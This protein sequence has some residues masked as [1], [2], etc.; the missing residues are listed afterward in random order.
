[1]TMLTLSFLCMA[2][3]SADLQVLGRALERKP[4]NGIVIKRGRDAAARN[5]EQC[6]D[7]WKILTILMASRSRR[8]RELRL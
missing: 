7:G 5:D 3:P 2:V 1:M 8:E 4:Q 6:G